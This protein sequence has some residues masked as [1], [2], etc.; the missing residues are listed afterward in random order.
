MKPQAKD[1]WVT[2]EIIWTHVFVSG[3]GEAHM[4]AVM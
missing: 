3:G 4:K 1:Q 2:L